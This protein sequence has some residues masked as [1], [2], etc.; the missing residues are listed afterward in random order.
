MSTVKLE[1]GWK[2][3]FYESINCKMFY[4]LTAIYKQTTTGKRLILKVTNLYANNSLAPQQ[5]VKRV[6]IFRMNS[7]ASSLR[8]GNHLFLNE[9]N[10]TSKKTLEKMNSFRGKHSNKH[11]L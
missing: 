9:L 1:E 2:V 10:P 11:S 6:K 4:L 8:T 3:R 7:S 5:T